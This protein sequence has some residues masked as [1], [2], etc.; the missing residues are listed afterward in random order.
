MIQYHGFRPFISQ[1]LNKNSE[2]LWLGPTIVSR[3]VLLPTSDKGIYT[4]ANVNNDTVTLLSHFLWWQR[5]LKSLLPPD[6]SLI[7]PL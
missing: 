1:I 3:R 7:M 2:T 5:T 4:L 6:T